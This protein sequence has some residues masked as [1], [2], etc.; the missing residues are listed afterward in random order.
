M[1]AG[2]LIQRICAVVFAAK[3]SRRATMSQHTTQTNLDKLKYQSLM[4]KQMGGDGV[5]RECGESAHLYKQLS[6]NN[7]EA[8]THA[9]IMIE[10]ESFS[11]ELS[12]FVPRLATNT[13]LWQI[14]HILYRLPVSC[15]IDRDD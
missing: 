13:F 8:L 7:M 2:D 4:T 9:Q 6:R 1:E 15:R 11:L 3:R 12:S 14:I 5:S 10:D